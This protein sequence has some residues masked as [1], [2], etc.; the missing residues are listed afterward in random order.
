MPL[1]T[2]IAFAIYVFIIGACVGS[3]LNVVIWRLPN[4][5]REVI[6]LD[7]RGKMTLSWPPSHCPVCDAPIHWYQNI[8]ILSWFFLRGKCANCRTGIPIRYP[9]VEL[10]T[11]L[12]FLALYLAYFVAEWQPAV[13][14][15]RSDWPVYLL[16]VIFASALLAA[17]AIDADLFIIPLQIPWF[18]A[19]LG[20]LASGLIGPPLINKTYPII[21]S[22]NN[23]WWLANP[24][25]GG[26]LGL[27]LA[28]ILMILKLMPRSFDGDL[29]GHVKEAERGFA[30]AGEQGAPKEAANEKE[31]PLPPPPRL[32]RFGPALLSVIG[33]LVILAALW[34]FVSPRAAGVATLFGAIVIFLIG[35]L[36][37]DEG[38]VDVTDEVL[39]E[40]HSPHVR[41]EVLKELLF[42][43]LPL[44]C[45]IVAYYVPVQL[46]Q[47]PWLS[48]VLG[49][50]LGILVGGGIVWM[51]RVA[52]SLAFGKEAMGM[53]DAHLM[54]GV[55][56][57]I[58]APLVIIAFFAAPFLGIL[59]AIVL[60]ILGKPNVL[61]YGPWLSVASIL[62]LLVGNLIISLIL[63]DVIF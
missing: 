58:G 4:R 18:L 52:G 40:I 36:P 26:M 43:G 50:F 21:P 48:R 51:I 31:Q 35:V 53:G 41:Q 37:R 25:I 63:R 15:L 59:W 60:K 10:G 57:V 2:L 12:L 39:E 16:H 14:D 7:Q 17:S 6:Y 20:V 3:F 61:P 54:A 11:A 46:P 8:P 45:A 55:G 13:A 38:Q 29:A 5:G 27:L 62:S 47:S 22:L 1:H 30:V 42:L 28:N 32:S 44:V 24:V 23:A 56:A 19:V 49:S 34:A 33:V 9:L